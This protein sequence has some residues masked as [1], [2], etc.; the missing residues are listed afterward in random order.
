MYFILNGDVLQLNRSMSAS[1]CNF[2][3]KQVESANL[4]PSAYKEIHIKQKFDV[5]C[6][7][8]VHQ[9]LMEPLKQKIYLNFMNL[10][11]I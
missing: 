9:D 4:L 1:A 10:M 7:H 11:A 2:C 8:S 5:N 3:N 6:S